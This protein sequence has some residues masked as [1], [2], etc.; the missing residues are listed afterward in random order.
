M[1]ETLYNKMRKYNIRSVFLLLL[2][3]L[4]LITSFSRAEVLTGKVTS[5]HGDVIEL[6][7]G[8][9]K[10]IKSGDSGRVYYT[11]RVGEKEK[12]IFIAK[13]KITHL[14]E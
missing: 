11:I 6:S 13:F 12:P 8:S 9:E 14:S 2:L 10:G 5:I 4:L 3:S 1:R 7:L